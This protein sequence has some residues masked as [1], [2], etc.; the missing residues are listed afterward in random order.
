MQVEIKYN[1]IYDQE[2]PVYKKSLEWYGHR[3]IT[4]K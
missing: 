4:A 3:I 2:M 1:D